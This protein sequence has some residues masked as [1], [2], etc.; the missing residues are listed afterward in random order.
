[1][2]R[3]RRRRGMTLV[4]VMVSA[5]VGAIALGL[6][7]TL[8]SRAQQD[9]NSSYI[10]TRLKISSTESTDLI[11]RE[12]Q[13]ATLSGEDA[14]GNHVLDTGEDTNRNGRL[15]ADWSL[16][17]GAV[18][19]AITFNLPVNGWLWSTP[20]TYYVNNGV[21]MRR[22]DGL[23][24]EICRVVTTFQLARTGNLVDID[25]TVTTKDRYGRTW[26]EASS[27]RAYVRN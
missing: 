1:V 26:T 13:L 16:A 8:T 11:V 12:L 15:D 7:A 2:K 27:R 10:R 19:N 25:L 24:R 5:A 22:Q 23:D 17:D 21:L 3:L 18:A 4:E 6:G 20:I 14:N 9:S